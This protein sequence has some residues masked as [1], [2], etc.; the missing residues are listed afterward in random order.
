MHWI[1]LEHCEQLKEIKAKSTEKKIVIFKHSTRCFISKMVKSKF[2]AKVSNSKAETEFYH[3]DLISYRTIS[4]EIEST[5]NVV[6]QS[7]Q[8]L[9]IKNG[10]VE[11][12]ASHYDIVTDLDI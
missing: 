7:P 10:V 12:H 2:E 8:V 6:H 1:A 9:V 5:F 3:L 11:A 4:N